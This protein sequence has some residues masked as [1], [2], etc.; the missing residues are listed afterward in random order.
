M[1]IICGSICIFML[2]KDFKFQSK[3]INTFA[4]V[5]FA[6]YLFEG[7]VRGVIDNFIKLQEYSNSV[8]LPGIITLVAITIMIVCYFI[9]MIR[10]KTI[11]K[12]ESKLIV[13]L[14]SVFKKSKL[15]ISDLESKFEKAIIRKQS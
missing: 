7:T 5:T 8:F 4:S 13:I 3:M 11:S 2:F 9:E 14:E 1:F 15:F 6:I 10:R 12:V